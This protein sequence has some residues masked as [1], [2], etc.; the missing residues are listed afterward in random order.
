[1][2]QQIVSARFDPNRKTDILNSIKV[3][4][5]ALDQL[6]DKIQAFVNGKMSLTEK[7]DFEK[8]IKASESLAEEVRRY[9]QMSILAQNEPLIT[10][11][12]MLHSMMEEIPIEP[13][14]GQY[15]QYFKKSSFFNPWGYWLS[16]IFLAALLLG[17]FVFYQKNREDKLIA[18]A[19]TQLLPLTNM[20]GFAPGDTSNAAQAMRAYDQQNYAEAAARLKKEVEYY[21][22]DN[23]LRL[24]LAVSYLMLGN[25][26]AAVKPLLSEIATTENLTTV[27]AKWYLALSQIQHG[28]HNEAR[29]LLKSIES[30]TIFGNRA[31]MI[32]KAF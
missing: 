6:Q 15:E 19:Q 27:P 30:D 25:H 24:Y 26:H 11:S 17:S 22:D 5:M 10:G 7:T 13:A 20:I 14:Y 9:R 21:P 12:A 18:L 23:S 29:V 28:E 8:E 4:K 16:G 2:P 1:M 3:K 31:Q 32:L